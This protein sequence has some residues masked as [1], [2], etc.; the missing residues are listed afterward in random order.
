MFWLKSTYT[1]LFMS[2]FNSI[3]VNFNL[4]QPEFHLSHW[5]SSGYKCI[6]A[7]K[8]VTFF[9][10][11]VIRARI[12]LI[13]NWIVNPGHPTAMYFI[14]GG[15]EA[16]NLSLQIGLKVHMKDDDVYCVMI[17]LTLKWTNETLHGVHIVER[18]KTKWCCG[19]RGWRARKKWLSLGRLVRL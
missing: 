15:W 4:C 11:Q 16:G 17:L 14:S 19:W 8:K 13:A 18:S 7:L 9:G 3:V 5:F 6:L 12:S 10:E 2:S 1:R